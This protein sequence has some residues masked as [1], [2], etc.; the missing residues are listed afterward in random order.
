MK[1]LDVKFPNNR[2]Q[3]EKQL[4]GLEKQFK[5]DQKFFQQN[6]QFVEDMIGNGMQK[7]AKLKEK[8]VARCWFLPHHGV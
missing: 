8:R 5:R 7:N 1:D 6:K 3:A 4:E 2:K